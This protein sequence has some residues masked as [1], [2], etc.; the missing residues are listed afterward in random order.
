[1]SGAAAQRSPFDLVEG[2]RAGDARAEDELIARFGEGISFLLRRWTRDRATAE[3]LYQETFRL[4]LEKIRKGEVREPEK[5]GG[6][7]QSLAKNL[8][9]AH[10]RRG[11]VRETREEDLDGVAARFAGPE[12]DEQLGRLL[13]AERSVLVRQVL[14][15]LK[16][17]RDRQ[18]LFRFYI[19]EE[20][21]E[22]ICADMGLSGT[23]LNM[24]LFRARRRF[25]D[26]YE[27]RVR[28]GS[29]GR[30]G[31]PWTTG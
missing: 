17:D 9:L 20:D 22:Q 13:R 11:A 5:L 15:E 4:A 27:R 19:S 31:R 2:I 30:Q 8:S 24:V 23:E 14:A 12:P 3:D 16:S 21:R 29:A 7:L 18:A 10:Y 28:A 26:L 25:R 1:M 6:F